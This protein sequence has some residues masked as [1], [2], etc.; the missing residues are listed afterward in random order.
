MGSILL[1]IVDGYKYGY[2]DHIYTHENET[3]FHEQF[4]FAKIYRE[5]HDGELPHNIFWDYLRVKHDLHPRRF[6]FYHPIVGHWIEKEPKPP[7]HI[8]SIPE[9]STIILSLGLVI[10]C[11]LK[12]L[13]KK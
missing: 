10:I 11:I 3:F 8:G 6:D 7:I 1:K 13:V 5:H 4:H 9:P 12:L 2:L